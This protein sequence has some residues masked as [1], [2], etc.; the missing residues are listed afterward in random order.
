M[1]LR[2]PLVIACFL[3]FAATAFPAIDAAPPQAG[4]AGAAEPQ[5]KTDEQPSKKETGEKGKGAKISDRLEV[6]VGPAWFSL[7]GSTRGTTEFFDAV[8]PVNLQQTTF[9]KFDK[10]SGAAEQI[11]VS[12]KILSRIA[13]FAGFT[14]SHP[15]GNNFTDERLL[16]N[17]AG[18]G[19]SRL[20]QFSSTAAPD[21]NQFNLGGSFRLLPTK[22]HGPSKRF[23]DIIV[24]FQSTRTHYDFEA[25]VQ[26]LGRFIDPNFL[27][28]RPIV[29]P[30]FTAKSNFPASYNM[31]FLNLGA[32]FKIG[33][34]I[35]KKL[36]VDLKFVTSLFGRYDGTGFLTN[37]GLPF[38]HSPLHRAPDLHVPG[39]VTDLG[40][41]NTPDCGLVDSDLQTSHLKV[42]Q[43]SSRSRGFNLDVNLDYSI[44]DW[45]GVAAGYRRNFA[46][47]VGGE[48]KRTFD[49]GIPPERGDLDR[50]ALLSDSFSV[51]GRFRFY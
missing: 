21:Y 51:V 13:A 8:G 35:S 37:H 16:G 48:E 46:R 26:K 34:Q 49:P 27:T 23:L 43:H 15:T 32:G 42:K 31:N 45:L 6:R 30:L 38:V 5:P 40:N 12:Y 44:N 2:L 28:F 3:S 1:P 41:P 47:S 39:C 36:S 22:K 18:P 33:G 17:L 11:D 25:G 14:I 24:E 10:A 7:R 4:G 20:V 19:D 9:D 29:D 50:A